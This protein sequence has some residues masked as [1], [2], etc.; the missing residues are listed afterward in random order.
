MTKN[1][2]QH[3]VYIGLGSN[4]SPETNLPLALELLSKR[5]D[6]EAV[7]SVWESPPAGG[8]GPNFLNAVARIRTSLPAEMLRE[9][10]LRE[11]ETQLG[12]V[13]TEDPNAPRTIDLDILIYNQDIFDP[14]IWTDT[15]QSVPLAEIYPDLKKDNG[16][17]IQQISVGLARKN[18]IHRRRD[19][20][21]WMG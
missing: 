21:T 18:A 10:I 3:P 19:I 7:S 12:R 9:S 1:N 15:H 16:E 13:R 17:T 11:I 2:N 20:I 14:G 5:V 8:K 4:I 6:L